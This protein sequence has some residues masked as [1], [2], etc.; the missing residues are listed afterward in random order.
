MSLHR[1][2]TPQDLSTSNKA[3]QPLRTSLLST[4]FAVVVEPS[5]SLLLPVP[6][7]LMLLDASC[8]SASSAADLGFRILAAT[9]PSS[10]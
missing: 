3:S 8:R 6:L 4:I 10:S 2:K 1:T 5:G 7:E 9:N